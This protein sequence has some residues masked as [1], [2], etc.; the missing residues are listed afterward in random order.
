MPSACSWAL[1]SAVCDI[2]YPGIILAASLNPIDLRVKE[3]KMD[4]TWL[5][6][7]PVYLYIETYVDWPWERRR[8]GGL[9]VVNQI[10]FFG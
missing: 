4:A 2:E 7:Y 1:G 5:T 3:Y 10:S 9:G 6:T 8:P